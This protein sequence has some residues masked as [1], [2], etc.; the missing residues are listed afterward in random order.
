V[1]QPSTIFREVGPENLYHLVDSVIGLPLV[2]KPVTGGSA[3]GVSYVTDEKELPGALVQAYAYAQDV[4]L[5]AKVTGH[6]V[7]VPVLDLG[8][9]PKALAPMLIEI[10]EGTSYDYQARYD[11]SSNV[12]YTSL[13]DDD[14]R[15]DVPAL[16]AVAEKVHALLGL[17]DFSR[18]DVMVGA[19]G[20]PQ[21]LEAA[22]TPGLTETSTF[23]LA[24]T[25]AGL[26]L[27]EVYATLVANA[28]KRGS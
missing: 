21:V 3:L 14:A 9:G 27:A 15:V 19:D 7:T 1:S 28:K 16:R 8:D 22:V 26:D 6:E 25:S 23:P 17:R 13:S 2:V 12:R 18:V 20:V 24:I 10:P 5:E 4:L 11:A